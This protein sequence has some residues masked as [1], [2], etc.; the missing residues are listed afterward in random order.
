MAVVIRIRFVRNKP[1]M[2]E[3]NE[4]LGLGP[5]GIG[6]QEKTLCVMR[7][8]KNRKTKEVPRISYF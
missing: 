5:A 3:K 6:T 1:S 2:T 4:N 8:I 7:A